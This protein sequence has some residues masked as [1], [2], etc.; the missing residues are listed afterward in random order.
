M[1]SLN[2]GMAT[3]AHRGPDGQGAWTSPNGRVTLAHT[4]LSIIDLVTGDQP[5]PNEDESVWA[6]V[7]GEF[8]GFK[9][10]RR[11]LERAGHS[12]RP[13]PTAKSY[14]TSTKI[15]ARRPFTGSTVNTHSSF[16]I[17]T[18]VSLSPVAIGFASSRCAMPSS[19]VSYLSL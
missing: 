18:T 9:D 12:S 17:T 16:G 13:N 4:R 10:I 6:V 5:I 7:N 3:L 19:T 1:P 14:C 8:Y 11:D 2:L 15:G